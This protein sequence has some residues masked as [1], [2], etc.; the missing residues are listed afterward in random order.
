ML[1]IRFNSVQFSLLIHFKGNRPR[2]ILTL[3]ILKLM[4]KYI[5]KV[6]FQF[7]FSPKYVNG[8]SRSLMNTM[9]SQ[10]CLGVKSLK[11]PHPVNI[12]ESKSHHKSKVM[13]PK[14][15]VI[16]LNSRSA[17]FSSLTPSLRSSGIRLHGKEA[18]SS[19]LCQ[20]YQIGSFG[21]SSLTGISQKPPKLIN[22]PSSS[23]NR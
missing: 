6:T 1:R 14:G 19:P 21:N 11:V 15:A 7:Y 16:S 23:R 2:V 8:S 18:G 10:V 5:F 20:Y 12:S 3:K 13:C 17:L 9:P 22:L 4:R